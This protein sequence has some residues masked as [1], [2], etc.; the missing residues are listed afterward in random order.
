MWT[1]EKAD[2]CLE[3][4]GDTVQGN[5]GGTK[6]TPD[7]PGPFSYLGYLRHHLQDSSWGDEIIIAALG[8]MWQLTVTIF[9][10]DSMIERRMRHNRNLADV[11][12]CVVYCG[13]SHYCAAGRILVFISPLRL[14]AHL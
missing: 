4:L 11:D 9:M 10:A 13:R 12:L 6:E 5:Y 2:Y 7:E 14:G 1:A 3:E 8:R